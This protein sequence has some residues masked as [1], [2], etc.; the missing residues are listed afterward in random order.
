LINN[1]AILQIIFKEIFN[2]L[3]VNV[4][5]DKWLWAVRIYKTRAQATD[6]CKKNRILINGKEVK[7]SKELKTG[8]IVTIRKPPVI[9]NFV[10][11]GLTN[12]R[13][14][15]K[16]VSEY[17]DDQTSQEELD[18]LKIKD[19][20]FYTR[21]RGTGRPTKKERRDIDKLKDDQL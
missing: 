10:V 3:V 13:L 11:K 15:A 1:F 18:K 12:N 6:A 16:F 4:R 2:R 21:D 7:P 9:Y 14:P 17:L 20:F 5:I 8:E 19:S